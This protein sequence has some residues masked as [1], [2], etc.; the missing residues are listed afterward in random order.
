MNS[1]QLEALFSA[2]L[3]N[4]DTVDHA[5]LVAQNDEI[6]LQQTIEQPPKSMYM[7]KTDDSFHTTNSSFI[8]EAN[9]QDTQHYQEVGHYC[10]WVK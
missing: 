6:L 9:H 10:T 4:N 7:E 8:P 3:K 5:R 2:E 1:K